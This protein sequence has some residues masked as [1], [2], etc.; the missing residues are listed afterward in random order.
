M[1]R[2]K[3]ISQIY[4]HLYC[5]GQPQNVVSMYSVTV[6]MNLIKGRW[7]SAVNHCFPGLSLGDRHHPRPSGHVLFLLYA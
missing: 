7:T 6:Y 5:Q 1:H 2:C 4:L 3:S